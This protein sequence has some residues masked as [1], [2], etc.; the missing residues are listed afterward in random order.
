M[1][2]CW[3]RIGAAAF[4][5]LFPPVI[6]LQGLLNFVWME[7]QHPIIIAYRQSHDSMIWWWCAAVAVGTAPLV[8]E[9]VF[10]G[11]LQGWLARLLAERRRRTAPETTE[12]T[13]VAAATIRDS[14]VYLPIILSSAVFSL[15]HWQSGPDFVPIFFLALG[16]GYLYRQTQ[17]IWP[18]V[19][20]HALLNSWSMIVLAPVPN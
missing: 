1:Q 2:S 19:I 14:E 13:A 8:E 17:S 15:M 9:F 7:S 12:E 16:L 20:V 6:A 11:V 4:A 5:V 10:R 3:L 18:G